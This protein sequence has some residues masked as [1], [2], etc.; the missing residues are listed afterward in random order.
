MGFDGLSVFSILNLN[1]ILKSKVMIDHSKNAQCMTNNDG[2][3]TF[4]GNEK[5]HMLY[6][7]SNISQ[8]KRFSSHYVSELLDRESDSAKVAA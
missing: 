2:M 1:Q 8:S 6:I 3:T 7:I 5:I 4:G